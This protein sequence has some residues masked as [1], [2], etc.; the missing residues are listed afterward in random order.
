MRPRQ[1]CH[2]KIFGFTFP[3]QAFSAVISAPARKP[4]PSRTPAGFR[5]LPGSS[6]QWR[7]S[8]AAQSPI[9]S[10]TFRFLMND[11]MPLDTLADLAF[12]RPD[13]MKSLDLPPGDPGLN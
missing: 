5:A 12:D 11:W 6:E 2:G 1:L 8:V 13:L 7:L 10:I 9:I 4:K 3:R